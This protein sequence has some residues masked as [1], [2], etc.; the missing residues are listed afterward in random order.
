METQELVEVSQEAHSAKQRMIGV[1]MAV[2][3][4]LLA[5]VTLMGHRLHTEEVVIQTKAAD[6]WAYYQAKNGRY[7]LYSTDAQLAELAGPQGAA[8]AATWNKKAQEEKAQAED[9]R[10][11]NEKLDEDT[12]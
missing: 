7:H 2:I 12:Q 5:V 6:G 11:V 3:A 1:T 9:V 10:K 8:L 4:A